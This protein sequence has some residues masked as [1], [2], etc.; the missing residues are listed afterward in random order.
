MK[1]WPTPIDGA[2]A[3]ELERRGDNRGFFSR[4][5]CA[6]EFS[7]SGLASRFVQINNSLS[8]KRGTL[9]GLHYQLV[10]N[11][12]VKIV[13]CICGSLW[14][15]IVDLRPDST[16]FGRWFGTELND[17][18]RL[19]M[20]VPRGVAHG[21]LTLSDDTEALYLVSEFYVPEQERGIRWDD[22]RFAIKWPILPSEISPKDLSWPDFD[23]EFH[24]IERFRGI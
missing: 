5:F 16:T 19:M 3:I 4:L 7:E 2:F 22:L 13:R 1:F 8:T 20:Y 6:T 21:I 23:P 9:R 18:N 24:G 10:P 11:A 17:D 12:E 14:D 15:A